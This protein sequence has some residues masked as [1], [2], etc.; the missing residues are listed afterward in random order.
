MKTYLC[1]LCLEPGPSDDARSEGENPYLSARR[2]WNERYGSYVARAQ[3]WRLAALL[4]LTITCLTVAGLIG[5]AMQTRLVPY[6]VEVDKLGSAV[7]VRRADAASQPDPRVI[8]AQLARWIT[9]MRSVYM[10]AAAERALVTEG[11]AMIDQRSPAYG[12]IN[13]YMRA[14]DPF[15]RAKKETVSVEVQSVLPLS[16][17]TWRLEWRED[18]RGRDGALV[19]SRQYQANV[20]VSFDPPRDETTIR[21]NP[22]GLYVTSFNWSVR[23]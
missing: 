16:R 11:Y 7:A 4:S 8:D 12:V 18:V 17:D 14:N 1:S 13:E 10:D 6:V 20:T 2:E 23:L 19:N 5:M 9:D 15:E 3:S 22:S 21:L